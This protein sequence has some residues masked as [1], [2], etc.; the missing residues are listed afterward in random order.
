MVNI[1]CFNRC[2]YIYFMLCCQL[3]KSAVHVL[4][5]N[6]VIHPRQNVILH[7][8]IMSGSAVN[9]YIWLMVYIYLITYNIFYCYI[10][11]C[12]TWFTWRTC[13]ILPEDILHLCKYLFVKLFIN[14]VY[15]SEGYDSAAICW[16]IVCRWYIIYHNE[17]T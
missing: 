9:S 4:L 13:N 17:C 5:C 3:H 2:I 8:P 12:L 16:L 11:T 14:L 10:V 6:V 15:M 7:R 1:K